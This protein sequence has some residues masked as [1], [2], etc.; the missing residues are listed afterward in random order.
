MA[1]LQ[2]YIICTSPRSGSTLLCKLLAAS[3]IAGNPGSHFHDPS[4]DEWLGYYDLVRDDYAS[5]LDLLGAIFNAARSC[6]SRDTGVFGL[7]LQRHSFD[8]FMQ[9]LAILHPGLASDRHR[10][11][12][13]FGDTLFIHLTRPDKLE[14]AVSYVKANQTGLWHMAPDGT[15]LERL[16]EPCEP[17]YDAA[18]I[19]DSLVELTAAD[20]AWQDWFSEQNI[21]P[22]K[23][24]YDELSADPLV[25]LTNLLER[26]GLDRT[27]ATGIEPGTAKLADT[28]S[29]EWVARFRAETMV[30]S[31]G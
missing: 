6:G 3:G 8:F 19:A 11:N 24:N 9:Q 23:I 5:D 15:E 16:S 17:V 18:A 30:D 10:L 21:E 22:Y 12:A 28:T 20:A 26:L 4:I 13:A 31:A 25:V 14:Q 7:R 1:D 27:A 2:S 29:G